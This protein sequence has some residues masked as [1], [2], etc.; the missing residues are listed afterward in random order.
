M[1]ILPNPDFR[2]KSS[3]VREVSK[4][5]TIR[6]FK[7]PAWATSCTWPRNL[8]WAKQTGPR[9]LFKQTREHLFKPIMHFGQNI[10]DKPGSS[11][12][13]F[14]LNIQVARRNN[15]D[16]ETKHFHGLSWV[17]FR[18]SKFA[19]M[20]CDLSMRI[21]QKKKNLARSGYDCQPPAWACKFQ[22]LGASLLCL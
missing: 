12:N 19:K 22:K 21:E 14:F 8:H 16:S 4:A 17:I 2:E 1:R 18:P 7:Y 3:P 20:H 10:S 5:R 15:F 6:R 13:H 11:T 9:R